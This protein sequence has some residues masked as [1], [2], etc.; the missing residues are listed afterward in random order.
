LSSG[1]VFLVFRDETKKALLPNEI[2]SLDTVRALF[3]RAFPGKLTMEMLESPRNKIYILET[4][5]SIFF[6][7]EDLR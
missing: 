3:V 1:V 6:Q 4:T 5:S 2:T 7:L